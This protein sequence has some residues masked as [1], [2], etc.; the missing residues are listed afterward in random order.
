MA[1]VM[2]KATINLE[3]VSDLNFILCPEGSEILSAAEQYPGQI[4]IWFRCDGSKPLRKRAI[5]IA[6]TGHH[7][8]KDAKF[9]GTIMFSNNRLVLHLFDRGYM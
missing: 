6:G 8:P 4:A 7:A 2:H 3:D 9:I 1:T 5:S